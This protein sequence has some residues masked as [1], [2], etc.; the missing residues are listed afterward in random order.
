MNE[1]FFVFWDSTGSQQTLNEKPIY[2]IQHLLALNV[3]RGSTTEAMDHALVS[4]RHPAVL[5]YN[6][7]GHNK[8][9]PRDL[10]S[11]RP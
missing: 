11:H 6:V 3:Q 8:V 4:S 9:S 1:C 2:T 7:H 5:R 10:Y